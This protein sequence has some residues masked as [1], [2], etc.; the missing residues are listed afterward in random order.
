M[1][2]RIFF[3]GMPTITYGLLGFVFG[4]YLN[5]KRCNKSRVE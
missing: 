2:E 3:I 4:I 1:V 5:K